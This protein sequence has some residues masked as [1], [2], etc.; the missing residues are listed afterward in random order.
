MG[1]GLHAVKEMARKPVLVELLLA[2]VEDTGGDLLANQAHVYLYATNKLLL[3]NIDNQRTFTTTAD[4]LVFLCELAWQMIDSGEL[5][6]HYKDIPSRI[7]QHFKEKI[8]DAHELDHW[9]FDLRNQ[10]H[11]LIPTALK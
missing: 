9:D 7:Q 4:K 1:A 10:T 5:R 6:I 3:R 11:T 2:A 8:K